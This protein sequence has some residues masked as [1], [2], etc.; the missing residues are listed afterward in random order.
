R[1]DPRPPADGRLLGATDLDTGA[2]ARRYECPRGPVYHLTPPESTLDQR[3]ARTLEAAHDQLA[4]G[5]VDA[6]PRAPGRAVRLVADP[7]DPVETLAAIL[8]KHT[9]GHGVLDD[10]F[11]DP[12]VSDVYVSTPADENPIRVVVDGV[13]MPTNVRLAPGG[14]ESLA[15]RLR[16]VSGASFSRADPTLDTVVEAGGVNVR[17][18]GVT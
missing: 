10:L 17:V 7:D 1:V 9:A 8:A 3:A 12:T 2:V 15:S 13:S 11:S 16:R 18:A 5:A 6:G 14:A 4:R